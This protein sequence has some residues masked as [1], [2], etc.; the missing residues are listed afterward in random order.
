MQK[1]AEDDTAGQF[2]EDQQATLNKV[3]GKEDA[4]L[5]EAMA[6]VGEWNDARELDTDVRKRQLRDEV[7]KIDF[8]ARS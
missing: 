6:K 4:T 3:V 1:I 8:I 5:D 2:A 7:S